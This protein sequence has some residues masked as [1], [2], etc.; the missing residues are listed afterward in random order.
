MQVVLERSRGDV[1][2]L[3]PFVTG[4]RFSTAMPGGFAAASFTVPIGVRRLIGHLG[5][6][7]ISEGMRVLFEGQVEDVNPSQVSASVRAFGTKRRLDEVTA[8]RIWS[9]RDMSWQ[10]A[11]GGDG[12]AMG[13][14][15]TKTRS[16][17]VNVGTYDVTDL[18]KKGVQV[19][20]TGVSIAASAGAFA[21]EIF[22]GVTFRKLIATLTIAGANTGA[23][24]LVGEILSSADGSSWTAQAYTSSQTVELDL[25]GSKDRIR[26][27]AYNA[28]AGALTP[29]N[30]DL[31]QWSNI[32]LLGLDS[33]GN[34]LSESV[35]GGFY[36]NT[37]LTDVIALLSPD[38]Y[39]GEIE[40]GGDFTIQQLAR[41]A[42]S[43]LSSIVQEVSSLY[44][45]D[46]AVWEGGRFDWKTR[47]TDVADL[48]VTEA[49]VLDWSFDSSIDEMPR[50]VYVTYTDVATGLAAEASAT[51]TSRLNPYVRLTRTKDIVV[52]APVPMTSNTASQL[53]AIIA[54]EAGKLPR[55][56]GSVTVGARRS[57]NRVAGG[58]VLGL[59]VR[60]GMTVHI[61]GLGM[62]MS[63]D[64]PSDSIFRI[65]STDVAVDSGTTMLELES[66][67]RRVD[68]L[69][70]RL[71]AVTR[72][73]S[74]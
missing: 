26:I 38:I 65:A 4:L 56:S 18:T 74:P 52:A 73:L 41:I 32:R 16:L 49:D 8:R 10:E 37:L 59:A 36:G 57:L 29:T 31:I 15:I 60:A 22:S 62:P 55:P 46:W 54:A 50:T 39:P 7:V 72:S 1:I 70:A 69:L 3:S 68:V 67:G 13:G 47:Q 33:S 66:P 2:D 34:V 58:Q 61:A 30:A 9:Y 35:A 43:S 21:E 6:L 53:A 63:I 11:P 19:A 28:G 14:S 64:D 23:G 45:R 24:K 25:G 42:R 20:G 48:I 27:G 51:A 40:Y 17:V 44:S 5:K 71:A 12:A